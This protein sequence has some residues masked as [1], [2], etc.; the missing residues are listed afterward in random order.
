MDCR[1]LAVSN[2][3]FRKLLPGR[4]SRVCGSDP[5]LV[6]TG[7]STGAAPVEEF[8]AFHTVPVK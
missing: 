1:I 7:F 3:K 4:L 5:V 2:L 6:I 8:F